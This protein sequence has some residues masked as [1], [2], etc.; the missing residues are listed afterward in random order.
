[1]GH[2]KARCVL[3]HNSLQQLD[4]IAVLLPSAS[5]VDANVYLIAR[6]ACR[7]RTH[8]HRDGSAPV[9]NPHQE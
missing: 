9:E 4:H 2:R 8:H 7:P 6:A 5:R 3:S 1:M